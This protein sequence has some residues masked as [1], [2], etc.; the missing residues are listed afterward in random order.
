MTL[1]YDV[2]KGTL[3]MKAASAVIELRDAFEHVETVAKWLANHPKD[4]DTEPLVI[5]FGY[6][7]DEAY[8]LR[9][10]FETF[11]SVRIANDNTFEIGRKITGLES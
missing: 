6:T 4:G 9:I 1:G 10:F 8:V 7:A 2:N 3:D 5:D 11:E